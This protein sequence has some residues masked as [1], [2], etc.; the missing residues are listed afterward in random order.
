MVVTL[1]WQK[2]L[3]EYKDDL[4]VFSFPLVFQTEHKP[5]EP[6][7]KTH[8]VLLIAAAAMS[9][10]LE[11]LC[12]KRLEILCRSHWSS[13]RILKAHFEDNEHVE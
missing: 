6:H 12:R 3:R 8:Q 10:R 2:E 7:L 13:I 11:I 9:E 4:F 5:K 1:A